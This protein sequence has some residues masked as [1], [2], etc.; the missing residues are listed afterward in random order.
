MS[1]FFK[2]KEIKDFCGGVL[3]YVEQP[4]PKIDAEI[5]QKGRSWTETSY[6]P[7]ILLGSGNEKKQ[8]SL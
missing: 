6:Y 3:L 2:V 8:H 4:N 5:V 1:N 7:A